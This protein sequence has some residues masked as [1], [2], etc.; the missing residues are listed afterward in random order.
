MLRAHRGPLLLFAAVALPVLALTVACLQ[1]SYELSS[2]TRDP[3]A[4][5]G[6]RRLYG[7]FSHLGVLAF[8]S[9]AAWGFLV[10]ALSYLH[11]VGVPALARA[12]GWGALL[13][14]VLALDDLFMVH[15]L[16]EGRLAQTLGG[17]FPILRALVYGPILL[18]FLKRLMPLLRQTFW[19][20]LGLALAG[21]GAHEVFDQVREL[22]LL[23]CPNGSCAAYIYFLEDAPKFVGACAWAAY[24]LD[25][26]WRALATEARV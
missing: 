9:A 6:G 10:A 16:V 1:E 17:P 5:V 2:L 3:A 13:S 25:L 11:G 14:G 20:L 8:W 18:L 15:E 4:V 21:F 22:G 26:A 24:H 19:P 7:L 23:A 12:L